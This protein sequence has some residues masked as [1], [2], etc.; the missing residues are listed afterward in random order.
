MCSVSQMYAF[1][2]LDIRAV[3][4]AFVSGTEDVYVREVEHICHIAPSGYL[5]HGIPTTTGGGATN[6]M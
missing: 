4:R 3:Y 1:S 2:V 5:F 6:V